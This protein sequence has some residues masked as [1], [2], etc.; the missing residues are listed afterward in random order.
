MDALVTAKSKNH[1]KKIAKVALK[2][3]RE[4]EIDVKQEEKELK[5]AEIKKSQ[6]NAETGESRE[7]KVCYVLAAAAWTWH[8]CP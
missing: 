1:R 8:H 5:Q 4:D 6:E 3:I 2:T 7:I